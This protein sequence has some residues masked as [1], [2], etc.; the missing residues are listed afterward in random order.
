MC[1]L[2]YD[3]N[4]QVPSNHRQVCSTWGETD[5]VLAIGLENR[6]IHFF[7]DEGEKI[8]GSAI[9]SRGAEI[10]TTTW[11]P[12]GGALAVGWSDGMVSLWVHKESSARE[13]NS[14]HTGRVSLLK[15]AP[16]GNRLI[17]AD[18]N[19]GVAVWKV[20]HRW[21]LSL[22]TTYARQ[23][24]ITHCVF[25]STPPQRPTKPGK[26]DG[27]VQQVCPSFFFGG[28][29]GS[30]HYADDLGHISDIQVLNHAV[31]SM[32]FYEE[33][34]R[35][36]VITRALQLIVF[37]IQSTDGTVK[38]TLKVKLSVAGDG[39]LRETKW[40]GP[41]LLAIASGEPLIRFWDLQ[42]EENS[43]LSLPK[44]GS[45]S[46]H[47][48]N[49]IDFSPRRRILV[50]G[51]T[52]GVVFFWRCTSIVVSGNASSNSGTTAKS[53][54]VTLSYRWD[55]IFTTDIQRSI[56]RIG[57]SSIYSMLYANTTEGVVIFHEGS[58]QRALCGDMAVIQSRPTTLSIE[59]FRDGMITQSTL[60]ATL[61]IK[62]V[63][64]DGASL[65]LWNGSKAE[66]YEL[67]DQEAKRISQ[68]K[69]L[70]N[71]MVLRGDS[72]YRTSGNHVEIC[73]MQ[74]VV[75]NTISFTEAEGRPAL[76][77][78]Q[79]K[80]LAV[81]TDRGLL[82]VFDLSRRDPKATGSMGNFLEAFGD[83]TKSSMMRGV[84]V[85]AD[86]TR[87]CILA[88]KLEGALKIRIP[89]SKLYLFQTDLNI[90]QQYDFGV[91]KYPLSVFFDP[92]EPRLLACETYKM[93][94]DA[95]SAV[96]A[97][98]ASGGNQNEESAGNQSSS[99]SSA[100][101]EK[102]ITILFA[103]NDH[104]I[105]MQDSFDLDLK[106]SAL[107]G[108]QVPRI[109]L[110][111]QADKGGN[112][113]TDSSDPSFSYLRT[114]IMRDF[115][116]LDKVNETARQALIDFCYYMTI[117][118]MDEAY[119]SVKLIDNPS[120][121][122][123]MAHMC[124]KTK[125]LDVAEVCLG[126][127]GHARGAAAVQEAKKEP[128][129]EVPIAMVAIQLGLL[130]DAA[131]LYRECGRYDLLNKLYQSS[132]YWQKATDVAA[133][134]D[135]I[136][137]KNTR[138]QL[139]KHLESMGDIKEAMEAYEEAGTHQKD[140]PR[141]LFKLGKLE[142]LQKYIST[143]KDRDMLVWW[144]QF[145]ESQG[146]FDL[147]I[148][149]YERAKD[150]L[151]IVRVLC[152]KKDFSH[153]AKVVETSGNRAAA[154]HLARQFEA[155]GEIS[156]AIHFYAIGNCYN[157]TIRLA[158]EHNLDAELMSFA[159]MSKPSDM[160]DCASYFESR[161]EM[162]KA[163]Q[164]YNKG[165]NVAKALELCFAAQL[166]EE[167]HYLTDEL[168]PTNTSPQLL[169]RCADFF[170]ANGHY[171]KAVHLCLI[172]GRVNEA[173]DVCMQHKVKVTEEMA[174]K[175]TP[176]KDDKDADNKVAQ[177][178]RT[179]LLLKLAKCCKQQGAYHLA[180]K[181]YT[182]AGEKVKAM[183]C[184]LKSG[185]TEKVV[186]FAN[187]SRNNDIY[188]LA[189]NY[190]QTLDWRKD[191]DILKNILGFY[192]K[193]RAFEQL[194]TFYQS[195]AQAEIEEYRDY[196]KALGAIQEAVKVLSKAKTE[197]KERLLK[198]SA[199]RLLLMEQFIAARQQIRQSPA[200][201]IPVVMKLLEEPGIDQA[202]RAGDAYALIV[203]AY[204]YEGDLQQAHDTLQEMKSKGLVLKTF[205][206]PRIIN[207]VHQKLGGSGQS[208]QKK[209]SPREEEKRDTSSFK[210]RQ[211]AKH[212][213]REE[214]GD[215]MEEDIAEEDD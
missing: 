196:E 14:P 124:V 192:T 48:V 202:I 83:E 12:R 215:D 146:Y 115:I 107:L 175:M 145:Q 44:S 114:K 67:R 45:S 203:E 96:A 213:P 87:V 108:I 136:H 106:Y 17:S 61:R 84:A 182:Q 125:R 188:V 4:V 207:D 36:I 171:A 132:S 117:G 78:V 20:D 164:L 154:Y 76:L 205:V 176:P 142:L 172:A 5:P 148:E 52:Q 34:N 167:L 49:N 138:Y 186:F 41:G 169:K 64:H 123:N 177:K 33:Q 194:A 197:N 79:N 86:G 160:L 120:V 163:V 113:D 210:A 6:E 173:L 105:L 199:G 214:E 46:A 155:M 27:F 119:R 185:D 23:G 135:R 127:M 89:V 101:A 139:A 156:R 149:S 212:S 133:K 69:C 147:A 47:Q 193:A 24:S 152:F 174:E 211:E 75:K 2:F 161:G 38:P 68:F 180:T 90:F 26:G 85:N 71:A 179:A 88:E 190:L 206:D 201:M 97:A 29:I 134:R 181:K 31:D 153:A 184:L 128:Q 39:S 116:G 8:P 32:M 121:W 40:A 98:T 53:G 157:H 10:V 93:K 187:V 65:V 21:Q 99:R 63:S 178:K 208:E 122:E 77:S 183:K 103:S 73:N 62:G 168:G 170:I 50:A 104:G 42:A 198:Q 18:E 3:Y 9:Y 43:V 144:A 7:S 151:S 158:K 95:L 109:Y 137:L 13:V 110:I 111:A 80:F 140:I 131:R 72:I 100:L 28:E 189:A 141:M 118:N 81:A 92:Q 130:D 37:Q 66:A 112:I 165:G 162:E 16:T 60:D 1:A 191:S 102:E 11:Q 159:L 200:E 19:G 126:N 58:M 209:A 25:A 70:S 150:D 51:T 22:A 57:W 143:S 55:L 91:N 56:T 30:V 59:K 74:G 15:W 82:R 129:I 166:F 54:A 94:P 35:L 195:C 204:Y